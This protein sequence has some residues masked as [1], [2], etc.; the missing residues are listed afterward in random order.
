MSSAQRLAPLTVNQVLG[1]LGPEATVGP[2]QGPA[3]QLAE[4]VQDVLLQSAPAVKTQAI[5]VGVRGQA[6]TS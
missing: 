1:S 5:L 6:R 2:G 4:L 3:V